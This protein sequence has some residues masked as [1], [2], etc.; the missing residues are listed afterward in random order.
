MCYKYQTM[1]QLGIVRSVARK[2]FVNTLSNPALPVHRNTST[3]D[4][5]TTI[6]AMSCASY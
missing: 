4:I 1:K 5:Y 3:L 6:E 2:Q